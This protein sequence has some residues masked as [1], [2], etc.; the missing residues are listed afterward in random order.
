V[1][2][3]RKYCIDAAGLRKLK[4]GMTIGQATTAARARA[5]ELNDK[6]W[7]MRGMGGHLTP[8]G[9]CGVTYTRGIRVTKC[10]VAGKALYKP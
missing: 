7:I 9:F 3:N 5:K 8:V 10:T 4:C 6:V 1:K 2:A